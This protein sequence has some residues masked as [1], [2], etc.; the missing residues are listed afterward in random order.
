MWRTITTDIYQSHGSR[1]RIKSDEDPKALFTEALAKDGRGFLLS[2]FGCRG[3]MAERGIIGVGHPDMEAGDSICIFKGG[4]MPF[5]LRQVQRDEGF[6]AY[7]YIGQAYIYKMM[8]G[9]MINESTEWDWIT[10]V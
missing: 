7:Q 3:F 6:V 8:D 9:E 5:V 10:L 4:N 1:R 2:S